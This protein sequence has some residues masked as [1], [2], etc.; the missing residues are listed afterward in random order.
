M[1]LHSH[2]SIDL[3]LR[4]NE[5]RKLQ[6][7]SIALRLS[8]LILLLLFLPTGARSQTDNWREQEKQKLLD[9]H[10]NQQSPVY[11]PKL[12][13]PNLLNGKIET[14][15]KSTW[16]F[17]CYGYAT[18]FDNPYQTHP[19]G[20]VAPKDMTPLQARPWWQPVNSSTDLWEL[21]QKHG[22]GPQVVPFDPNR[23]SSEGGTWAV[24]Y[25][26]QQNGRGF[27]Q[28]AAIWTSHGVFAKM[29]QLGTFRFDSLEQ[30]VAP[31]YFGRPWKMMQL[32]RNTPAPPQGQPPP[33][34]SQG[35]C[36][37]G[38][39]AQQVDDFTWCRHPPGWTRR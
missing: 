18:G 4:I 30:M 33:R 27:L 6:M 12:R 13:L 17:N 21:F 7:K 16:Q 5:R 10:F 14:W 24:F 8:S 35:S 37:P 29:G 20:W 28:H 31:N 9:I 26:T 19:S 3:K 25:A 15:G 38:M 39:I 36:L 1:H 34:T 11:N 2:V 23:L 22:W 32:R